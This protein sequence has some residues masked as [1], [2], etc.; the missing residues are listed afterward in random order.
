[1]FVVLVLAMASCDEK[2]IEKPKNLIAKDQ[3]TNVLFDLAIM[4]AAKTT[5]ALLLQEHDLEPTR[6][7]LEKYG[8]DSVQFAES[9]KYYASLPN[10]EYAA[11]YTVIESRLDQQKTEMEEAKKI[12]D[13][14][15]R[16]EAKAKKALRDSIR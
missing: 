14:L 12:K 15:I 11:M 7:V 4:N 10:G 1:M 8:I 13:S 6:F 3:M 5:N 2:L 16:E 9:D